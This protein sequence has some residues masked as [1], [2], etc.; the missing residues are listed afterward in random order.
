MVLMEVHRQP[1]TNDSYY[2]LGQQDF[3]IL[4]DSSVDA[5]LLAIQELFCVQI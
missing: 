2:A 4:T 3:L 5:F 1:L